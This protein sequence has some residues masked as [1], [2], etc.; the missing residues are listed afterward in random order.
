MKKVAVDYWRYILQIAFVG[1]ALILAI[2]A[3][4]AKP[5]LDTIS[6]VAALVVLAVLIIWPVR[7]TRGTSE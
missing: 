7:Q 6:L 2:P 5:A 1:A 3:V 4:F